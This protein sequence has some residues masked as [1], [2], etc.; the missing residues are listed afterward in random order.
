MKRII[1]FLVFFGFL[2]IAFLYLNKAFSTVHYYNNTI[3]DFKKL[4]K[5]QDI[6]VI[7]Y[8]SSH[9]YTAF[10][11]IVIDEEA[12]IVS[13]NLGS[14]SQR[15]PVTNLV[16]ENSLKQTTPKL[17]ILEIYEPSLIYPTEIKTKGFQLRALDFVPNWSIEKMKIMLEIY[18]SDELLAAYFPIIRNHEKWRE[19]DYF[20][21]NRTATIDKEHNYYYNGFLG[22]DN[23]LVEEREKYEYFRNHKGKE[24]ISN[25][26][27][28]VKDIKN[29]K[30]FISIANKYQIPILIVTS[31]YLRANYED[32]SFF[33]ALTE[34]C[35]DFET[36]YLNLNNHYEDMNL[37]LD[38]FSDP[39]HLN[40]HG[41]IKVSNYLADYIN[42][43]YF[44]IKDIMTFSETDLNK[45]NEFYTKYVNTEFSR[46]IDSCLSDELCIDDFKLSR[47]N[48]DFVATFKWNYIQQLSEKLKKYK[49]AV[50]IYPKESDTT[51]LNDFSKKKGLPFE[52]A[53]F[54]FAGKEDKGS[55]NFKS[56]LRNFKQ[57]KLFLYDAD[58]FK[59]IVGNPILIEN[60]IFKQNRNFD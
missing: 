32:I 54:Q 43:N 55:L 14:D 23:I 11:P 15:L 34:L 49:L 21:L 39:G 10:I 29:I 56:K 2:L 35:K 13:Y 28:A 60:I 33:N 48:D 44:F 53:D 7:F 30:K 8:G 18:D 57:I 1:Y 46:K 40:T 27:L 5:Q 58:G 6:D 41:A 52:M 25:K 50:H 36:P 12:N 24:N 26:T 38:D 16:F 20:D 3:E 37:G 42:N 17:A 51:L 59:G 47:R 19:V 9:V 31:P 45:R 22:R 4:S